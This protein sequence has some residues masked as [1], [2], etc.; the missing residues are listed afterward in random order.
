M[1]VLYK[2]RKLHVSRLFYTDETER[3]FYLEKIPRFQKFRVGGYK[4]YRESEAGEVMVC[5][6]GESVKL[7]EGDIISVEL[8]DQRS[9]KNGHYR[10][11]RRHFFVYTGSCLKEGVANDFFF[12]VLG[13][14]TW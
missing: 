5:E 14:I 13:T 9:L 4:I 2:D 11:N 7:R 1:S 8:Y 3:K 6:S 12:K 10:V